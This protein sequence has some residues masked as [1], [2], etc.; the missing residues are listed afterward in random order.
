M[1]SAYLDAMHTGDDADARMARAAQKRGINLTSKS[2]PLR[3][4][5]LQR[6]DYIVGMD[7]MNLKA[8]EV[9]TMTSM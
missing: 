9:C 5:D 3:P 8:M 7:P 1:R 4:D 6:F 2:R